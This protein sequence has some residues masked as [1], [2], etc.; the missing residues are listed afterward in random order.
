MINKKDV[1]KVEV[2]T[3]SELIA[4]EDANIMHSL[5]HSVYP[6]AKDESI[7]MALAYCK[8]KRYDPLAKAV[9]IM[10]VS[11][12]CPNTNQYL[13]KDVIIPGI[14]AYR[15]DAERSGNYAGLTRP[16]F[17]PMITEEIGTKKITYPE[18]CRITVK[19]VVQ[20]NICDFEAEE[21]WKEN[22]A[23][24]GRDY[25][26]KIINPAPNDM[27][28][29]RARG[30]LAKCTEAQAL[31]KA[32]PGVVGALPTFEE[33]EGKDSGKSENVVSLVEVINSNEP[34]S[35]ELLVE[36]RMV[37]EKAGSDE[38]EA[39][40]N[41]E[42]DCLESISSKKAI[43]LISGLKK[44]MSKKKNLESLPINQKIGLA[45]EIKP[46]EMEALTEK[47]IENGYDW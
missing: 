42:V 26:T 13:K 43:E 34:V 33:M 22:Y 3:L 7:G 5:R 41:L 40:F 10:Q 23:N 38:K 21:Y 17:G 45:T 35:N 4:N 27:W 47:E 31:R 36:L 24:K 12:K 29:K 9:H 39:C 2:R 18:W 30:Q 44:R 25:K 11:Y 46:K 6:G 28:E 1:M 8:A 14:A 16:E 20:N 37:M 32:F 15:I 19:K